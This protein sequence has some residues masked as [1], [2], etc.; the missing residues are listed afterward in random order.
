MKTFRPP[1]WVPALRA[2]TTRQ[3]KLSLAAGAL[4]LVLL[5]WALYMPS[6]MAIRRDSRR[7]ASLKAEMDQTQ[8]LLDLVR[9]GEIRPLPSQETLPELLK[10][11][12]VQAKKFQVGILS[13]SPGRSDAADP[14]QPILLPVELQVEGEY[15]AIGQFLGALRGEPSLGMVTVRR[16]QMDRD[17]HL[18]PRLRAQLSIEL[19][20]KQEASDGV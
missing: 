16:F 5:G 14:S 11:V 12:H 4:A 20:L 19:A 6:C 17:E 8:G 18:L 2:W 7:C 9:R 13:I 1:E 10:Q 15:R 3:P